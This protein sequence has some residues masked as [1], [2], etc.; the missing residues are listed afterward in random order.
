MTGC[1]ARQ[2]RDTTPANDP[3]G[4]D[5]G[6]NMTLT[7]SLA[8]R[9]RRGVLLMSAAV[10]LVACGGGSSQIEDFQALQ[11]YAFGDE[12]STLTADGRRYS[13][14]GLDENGQLD[15]TVNPLWVQMVANLF[16][17]VFAECNPDGVAEPQAFMHAAPGAKVADLETQI[18]AVE[19]GSGF[20]VDSLATVL[21]GQNDIVEIYNRYDPDDDGRAMA[22]AQALGQQIG[23]QVNRLIRLDVRVLVATVPDQ[24]LTPYARAEKEAHSDYNRAKVLSRLT[25]ALNAAMRITIINDGRLVGLVLADEMVQAMVKSPG[26]FG[27]DDAE[28]AVCTV[29]LPDCNSNT[30]VEDGD[31]SA[32]LWADDRQLSYSGQSRMGLL[33]QSRARDNPF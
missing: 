26:S 15:C 8:R 25:A 6:V 30:L 1:A 27:L 28:Q 3:S 22:E 14:N 20:G 7:S 13:V 9:L 11:M 33:A 5:G 19:A 12:A 24:G 4:G 23:R 29:A 31:E 32:W 18:D 21:I 16:D 17:L 10:A 2:R